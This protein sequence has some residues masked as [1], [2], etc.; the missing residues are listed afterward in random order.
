M[1]TTSVCLRE[2]PVE[3]QSHDENLK[4]EGPRTV[5]PREKEP[6]KSNIMAHL[7]LL[8]GTLCL[9]RQFVSVG[10]SINTKMDYYC[11]SAWQGSY[12]IPSS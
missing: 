10:V 11:D 9:T 12:T 4:R 5:M 8:P 7:E 2:C 1:A 3:W 6:S